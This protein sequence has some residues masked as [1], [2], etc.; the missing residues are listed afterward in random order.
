MPSVSLDSLEADVDFAGSLPFHNL[1]VVAVPPLLLVMVVVVV[2]AVARLELVSFVLLFVLPNVD[3]ITSG[4]T[5]SLLSTVP[6]FSALISRSSS[7]WTSS[8]NLLVDFTDLP[9]L[10]SRSFC[11]TF[12]TFATDEDNDADVVVDVVVVV[13]IGSFTVST[14]A[15]AVDVDADADDDLTEPFEID[16]GVTIVDVPFSVGFGRL[17]N[18]HAG[19]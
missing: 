10:T 19:V 1:V 5:L 4:R 15:G 9:P 11:A 2:A 3:D 17:F 8:I 18:G 16:F 14:V 13:V 12:A 7:I 6:V